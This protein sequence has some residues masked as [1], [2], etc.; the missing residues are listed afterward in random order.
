MFPSST[1]GQ[2]MCFLH[3]MSVMLWLHCMLL[4]RSHG[5]LFWYNHMFCGVSAQCYCSHNSKKSHISTS[6]CTAT[7]AY[8]NSIKKA[9]HSWRQPQCYHGAPVL[10]HTAC[11]CY[12]SMHQCQPPPTFNA[13]PCHT[14]TNECQSPLQPQPHEGNNHHEQQQHNAEMQCERVQV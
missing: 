3:L 9:A 8:A 4:T 1:P 14:A 7:L 13:L 11:A 10:S 5:Q 12:G 6:L 2:S